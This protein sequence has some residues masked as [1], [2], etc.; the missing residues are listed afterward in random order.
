MSGPVSFGISVQ[1]GS[2]T[3]V[4]FAMQTFTGGDGSTPDFRIWS[5][6]RAGVSGLKIIKTEGSST[7]RDYYFKS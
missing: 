1:K 5:N 2:N 7:L 3:P 6:T 4:E